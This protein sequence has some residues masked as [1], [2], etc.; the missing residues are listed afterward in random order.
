[1][2]INENRIK[3]LK[4]LAAGVQIR[5]LNISR[6]TVTCLRN[7]PELRCLNNVCLISLGVVPY[8]AILKDIPSDIIALIKYH[9]GTI[10]ICEHGTAWTYK[11]NQINGKVTYAC[12]C[13]EEWNNGMWIRDLVACNWWCMWE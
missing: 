4:E 11:R 6:F 8:G 9:R 1:M 2:S 13:E 3:S 5:F 10:V 12:G 7:L